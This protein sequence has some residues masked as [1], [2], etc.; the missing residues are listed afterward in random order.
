MHISDFDEAIRIEADNASFYLNRAAVNETMGRHGAAHSDRI[1]ALRL[2]QTAA[3]STLIAEIEELLKAHNQD[4]PA[5]TPLPPPPDP[6]P[7]PPSDPTPLPPSL[8]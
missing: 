2:A 7:L 1:A 6:T 5:P 3:D 8:D 4:A